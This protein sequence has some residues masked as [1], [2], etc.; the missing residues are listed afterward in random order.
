[1]TTRLPLHPIEDW[2]EDRFAEKGYR[3]TAQTRSLVRVLGQYPSRPLSVATIKQEM[4]L[5]ASRV[6]TTTVYRILERLY[7]VKAI[8]RVDE[9]FILC[10]APYNITQQ[11]HFLVCD[12]CGE[13]SEIFLDYQAD[14][15]RQ[16]A[17]DRGFLLRDVDITFRGT[18]DAC[19][20][21][22]STEQP[23]EAAPR[24]GLLASMFSFF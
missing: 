15:Q 13:V 19:A 9:G 16:L 22:S 3:M 21:A 10:S 17:R 24:R 4:K 11:H 12:E 5:L 2:V 8:H 20:R 7:A 23:T 18:C 1:M 6:D 14:I